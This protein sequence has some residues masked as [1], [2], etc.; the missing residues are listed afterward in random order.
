ME[1]G[2]YEVCFNDV[3]ETGKSLAE[4][5]TNAAFSLADNTSIPEEWL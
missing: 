3:C 5:I 2:K 1:K 4:A